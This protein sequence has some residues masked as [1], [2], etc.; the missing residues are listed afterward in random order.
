M[1]E[2]VLKLRSA[3]MEY[4]AAATVLVDELVR[5]VD[6]YGDDLEAEAMRGRRPPH[7]PAGSHARQAATYTR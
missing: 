6:I 7:W 5:D 2:V 4:L 3:L 1:R